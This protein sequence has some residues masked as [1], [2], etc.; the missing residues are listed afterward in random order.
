MQLKPQT[1]KYGPVILLAAV[2][3]LTVFNI[4]TPLRITTDSF[5]YFN[6]MEYLNGSLGNDSYAAVD[7]YPH[8]YPRLLQW[9]NSCHLLNAG[10]LV[11]INILSVTAAAYIFTKL[12]PVKNLPVFLAFVLLSFINIKHI[13]LP[14]A[15]QLF[16]LVLFASVLCAVKGFERKYYWFVP[17]III[18]CAGYIPENGG[19]GNIGQV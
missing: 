10:V 3:I 12:F 2:A 5:R 11:S 18:C 7:F 9:L 1:L 14:I 6:I 13:T 4:C 19:C 16:T 15:D 17:A 8:G